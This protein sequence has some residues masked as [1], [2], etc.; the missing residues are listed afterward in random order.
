MRL[1]IASVRMESVVPRRKLNLNIPALHGSIEA[2]VDTDSGWL[3]GLPNGYLSL[4]L[5]NGSVRFNK[6]CKHP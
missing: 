5:L 4:R 3:G 6:Q 2:P 1:V